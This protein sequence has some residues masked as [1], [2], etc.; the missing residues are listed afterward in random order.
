MQGD[1]GARAGRWHNRRATRPNRWWVWTSCWDPCRLLPPLLK[2][3]PLPVPTHAPSRRRRRSCARGAAAGTQTCAAASCAAG[4]WC[5]APARWP[6]A[7]ARVP[8]TARTGSSGHPAPPQTRHP[9]PGPAAWKREGGNGREQG[10]WPRVPFA[11]SHGSP[12]AAHRPKGGPRRHGALG[13]TNDRLERERR[14]GWGHG[15]YHTEQQ[16]TDTFMQGW[17]G[18][19]PLPPGLHL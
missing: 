18:V 9:A 8:C 12:P 13:R 6:P 7:T 10:S 4:V 14:Q 19:H 1:W 11:T 2:A 15:M 5:P 16:R 17:S 3:I